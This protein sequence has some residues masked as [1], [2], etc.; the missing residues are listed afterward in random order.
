M[1][2][3][4]FGGMLPP[5]QVSEE[6]PIGAL[7]VPPELELAL[8]ETTRPLGNESVKGEVTV[9]VESLG[10]LMVMVSV[11]SPPATMLDGL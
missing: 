7:I 2:A 10:L 8:P 1:L 6:P 11:E 9:A 4:L 5:V 3:V